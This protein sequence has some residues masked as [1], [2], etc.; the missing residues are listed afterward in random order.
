VVHMDVPGAERVKLRI[1][2]PQGKRLVGSEQKVLPLEL[3]DPS[4]ADRFSMVGLADW[5]G[6][7][8]RAVLGVDVAIVGVIELRPDTPTT[9]IAHVVVPQF[10]DA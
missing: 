6:R 7:K 2:V 9:V 8:V 5:V 1:P 10:A 3:D 4:D